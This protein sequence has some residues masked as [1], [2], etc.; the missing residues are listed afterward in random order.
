VKPYTDAQWQGIR[1]LGRRVDADLTA[2]D[3]RLTQGGEPTFVAQ[4]GGITPEWNYTALGVE[5]RRL[6]AR[7]LRRLRERFAPQGLMLFGQ[8]K[9][10]PGEALPRWALGLFWRADGAP[11]WR[12]A[13]WIADEDVSANCGMDQARRLI[14]CL[15]AQLAV[16]AK[17]I[18]PAYEDPWSALDAESRLP[19]DVDPLSTNLGDAE[20]RARL[21]RLLREGLATVSG[22]ALPLQPDPPAPGTDQSWRSE[23]WRLR[24]ERLYLVPGDSPMGHRLPL[25]AL[26]GG[27]VSARTALCVQARAGR[28]HVFIP[29]I[30]A[31]EAYIALVSLVERCARELAIPVIPE[32]YEPPPDVALAA[33]R[34][35]PDPGVLEVNVHPA[36]GWAALESITAT[37]YEEARALGLAAEKFLR[38]GRRSAT[39]GGSHITLGGPTPADSPLLRRPD[40]LVSLVTFWQNHPALSYVFSGLFV[41]ATSQAPRID[42]GREGSLCELEIAFR[43]LER[44]GRTGTP[45]PGQVAG[46]LRYLL[47]DVTGNPHR[48]EFCIDKLYSE[49]NPAGRLGLLE[50]RGFEMAPHEHMAIVQALLVRSLVALFWASPYRERL[51]PWGAALHDRFML[52]HYLAADLREVV[53]LLN[54]AGYQFEFDWFGPFFEFRFPLCGVSAFNGLRIEL[55]HALEPWPVL[56]EAS[57]GGTSRTVDASLE[58][59]QVRVSGMDATR[60]ALACNGR[61]VPLRP[62]GAHGEHV[63]GVRFRA[64]M[65]PQA[66]HP[67]IDVHAPL[68]FDLFETRS[69]RPLGGCDYHG[70]DPGGKP[71]ERM[72]ADAAEAAARRAVRFVPRD[73][74][75]GTLPAQSAALPGDSCTLDLRCDPGQRA[76]G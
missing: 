67:T 14:E 49:D 39:G 31:L 73:R 41:G 43:E 25:D 62:T 61:R 55:R 44:L 58:R 13:T 63:A 66:L 24:R 60:H 34:I 38:D 26:P 35:T 74:G 72:P 45:A 68:A 47:V 71:S 59:V 70:D 52:P 21:A 40:L 9:S 42:E 36:A 76:P 64:R 27:G 17:F 3:V 20:E 18:V 8:G 46:L 19:V 10:Y 65:L 57:A 54:R 69:G 48:S 50:L 5:K 28:I 75:A 53:E 32:G 7:L 16:D 1:S 11:L 29:P 6:A 4:S 22:Y 33:L 23:P 2:L 30:T 51:I 15:A 37:V 12:D 56:G